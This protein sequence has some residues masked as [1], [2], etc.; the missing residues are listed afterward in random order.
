M[1]GMIQVLTYLL[2]I[3]LVAKGVEVLMLAA[4]SS[5]PDRERR[6]LLVLGGLVLAAC[7][8]SACAI[9]VLQEIQARSIGVAQ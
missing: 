7:I 8:F 9:V 2:G 1:V 4:C 3:Y 5:R 6:K